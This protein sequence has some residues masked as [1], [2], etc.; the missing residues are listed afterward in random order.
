LNQSGIRAGLVHWSFCVA[1]TP[2]IRPW[3]T[4]WKQRRPCRLKQ[5]PSMSDWFTG[6]S[7]LPKLLNFYRRIFM[8]EN[9]NAQAGGPS[10]YRLRHGSGTGVGDWYFALM[11]NVEAFSKKRGRKKV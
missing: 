2:F 4:A 1:K 11:A 10:R 5:P 8:A 6:V 7:V 3:Q 9:E